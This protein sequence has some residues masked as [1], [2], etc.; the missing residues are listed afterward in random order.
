[1]VPPDAFGAAAVGWWIGNMIVSAVIAPIL[2]RTVTPIVER[3]GLA[4]HGLVT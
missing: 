2:L 1:L 3:Y 4:T